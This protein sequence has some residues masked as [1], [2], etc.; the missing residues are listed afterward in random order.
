[1]FFNGP[2]TGENYFLLQTNADQEREGPGL[3]PLAVN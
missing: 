2:K 3:S 1:M